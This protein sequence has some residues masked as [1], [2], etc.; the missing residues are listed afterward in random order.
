M[1]HATHTH[2]R[3]PGRAS[4]GAHEPNLPLSSVPT[5]HCARTH[6]AILPAVQ[7]GHGRARCVLP[8]CLPAGLL[9]CCTRFACGWLLLVSAGWVRP[10]GSGRQAARHTSV[11][12]RLLGFGPSEHGTVHWS[13]SRAGAAPPSLFFFSNPV[14]FP[15]FTCIIRTYTIATDLFTHSQ[16]ILHCLFFF[17]ETNSL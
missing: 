12:L 16:G 11:P 13:G 1:A 15:L 9:E 10:S 8:A 5:V 4:G 14:L 6:S 3:H 17:S 2:P 7:F